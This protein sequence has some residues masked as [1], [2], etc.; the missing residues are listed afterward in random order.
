[1][2]MIRR[3]LLLSC[4]AAPPAG[5]H[6]HVF[7]DE[8]VGFTT[9]DSS[10]TGLRIVWLYDAFSTLVLYDQL[11]LDEDGDGLL[12][13]ADLA[14]VAIGETEWADDYEGDTYL[15]HGAD[16]LPLGRPQ[17]GTARMVGD[18]VEVTFDLPL[19][20]PLPMAG[21]TASLKM[22]DPSYYYAYAAQ[23]VLP[24]V[25]DGCTAKIIPFEPTGLDR[26]LQAQLSRLST[27]EMPDD[28]NIGARFAEEVR[29]TCD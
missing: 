24:P 16:K 21:R 23:A 8:S 7:V 9:E 25:P 28:P 22:Y 10:L 15:F 13:D 26:E 20:S 4:L 17:G 1:M 11:W 5:A 3:I 27:E 29:L 18:R 6:P 12:N 14:K 19:V 2:G